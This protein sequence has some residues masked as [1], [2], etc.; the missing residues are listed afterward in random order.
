MSSSA[1]GFYLVNHHH[2]VLWSARCGE[3]LLR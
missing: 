1:A 3:A 2:L